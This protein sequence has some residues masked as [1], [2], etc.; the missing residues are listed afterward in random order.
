M[1]FRSNG[2]AAAWPMLVCALAMAIPVVASAGQTTQADTERA[3]PAYNDQR[4][5]EDW[6]QFRPA[7]DAADFWDPVKHIALTDDG[8]TWL[9]LGG[10]V[11]ERLEVWD[12]F[13]FGAPAGT[14]TDDL[15]L[16]S[17][18][19]A[20]A[21]LHVGEHVR[22]FV[23]GKSSLST[24]TNLA[25]RNRKLDIDRIDLQNGFL[26]LDFP[27]GDASLRLRGG[28]EDL[29]FGRQRLVSPLDWSNTLRSWDG[30]T[31]QVRIGRWTTNGFWTKPVRIQKN[32]FNAQANQFYGLYATGSGLLGMS[33]LDLYWMGLSRDGITFNGTTGHEDRHTLGTRA[34]GNVGDSPV[35][36]DGEFAFQVGEV[37][38]ADVFA[39]MFSGLVGAPVDFGAV[40]PKLEVGFDYAS[41]DDEA[42]NGSVQTF[43][44]L[45]PLGHAYLGYIDTI[46][47]QNVIAT[48][49][50]VSHRLFYEITGQLDLHYF[51]R[52]DKN[53]ALYNAGGGV[54]RAGNLGSSRDVGAEL[55]T[56]LKRAFG[57]HT[58]V[59][60]GYSHFFPGHFI[61]QSG[62]NDHIDFVYLSV[63]YVL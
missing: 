45:F 48:H 47:R 17:R 46:G 49:G 34:W 11:R 52:A 14:D 60:F 2:R 57:L 9:S 12:G 36:Y 44:Q 16:L 37:G 22:M 25:S 23:Q 21:D 50:T 10:Q 39:F 18:M 28:R 42:G 15:L 59:L 33:G 4:Q 31:S 43:N 1:V 24:K 30:V 35:Y 13:N 41:G 40:H 19:L 53:D 58:Q 61:D 8:A 26:E 20:H 7:S 38:G 62:P 6:S 63:Q 55:D 27:L 32:S 29:L 5:N 3:R 54:V 56:T 51:W